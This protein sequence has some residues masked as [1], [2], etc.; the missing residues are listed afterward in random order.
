MTLVKTISGKMSCFRLVG[1]FSDKSNTKRK[2][3]Q[4]VS[5]SH[6]NLLVRTSSLHLRP[7]RGPCNVAL[8][9]CTNEGPIRQPEGGVNGSR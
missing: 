6:D 3:L 5:T 1:S 4:Q 7:R 2:L 8:H 9:R